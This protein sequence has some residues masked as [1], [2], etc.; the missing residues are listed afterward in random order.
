MADDQEACAVSIFTTNVVL[1]RLRSAFH[2]HCAHN[3]SAP[4]PH[5]RLIMDRAN[6]QRPARLF[7]TLAGWPNESPSSSRARDTENADNDHVSGVDHTVQIINR[8][9][10]GAW[11]RLAAVIL[12]LQVGR[13]E[14]AWWAIHCASYVDG[15]PK[16]HP[17]GMMQ[18]NF[19]HSFWSSSLARRILIHSASIG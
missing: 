17:N 13:L 18:S 11:D 6:N 2:L 12:N 14:R 16:T 8:N 3:P 5:P 7:S 4:F 19:L 10:T 15:F 1:C 9:A